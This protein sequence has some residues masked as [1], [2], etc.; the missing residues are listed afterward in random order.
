[1][2]TVPIGTGEFRTIHSRVRW[3][4]LP[5]ERSMTV[6]APQR[7]AH[8]SF[9]TSSSIEEE[10][11]EFPMFALIFTRKLRPTIIGSSSGWRMLAGMIARPRASSSRTSS[12]GRFSRRAAKRISSL[13]SPRRA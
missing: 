5:V 11:A 2:G 10:M 1:M 9:S 7:T 13:I 4:S 3:M 6:S 8:W 12:T